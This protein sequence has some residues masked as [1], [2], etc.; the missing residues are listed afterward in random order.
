MF[1][2]LLVYAIIISLMVGKAISNVVV[3]KGG[4]LEIVI[5]VGAVLFFASDMCLLFAMFAGG[6][7]TMDFWCLYTYYPSHCFL[8]LSAIIYMLKEE[9]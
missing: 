1:I 3:T 7:R 8:A 5:L 2:V 4:Y 6:G 9:N